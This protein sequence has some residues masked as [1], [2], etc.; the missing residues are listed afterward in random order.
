MKSATSVTLGLWVALGVSLA[1]AGPNTVDRVY[2]LDTGRERM[3]M[4]SAPGG[5][6]LFDAKLDVYRIYRYAPLGKGDITRVRVIDLDEDGGPEII[7]IGKPSFGLDAGGNPVWDYPEGCSELGVGDL[8]DTPEKEVVCVHGRTLTALSYNGSMMWEVDLRGAKMTGLGV[9][10]LDTDDGKEDVEVQVGKQIWRYKGDGSQ[11]GTEFEERRTV[12]QDDWAEQ[13]AEIKATLAGERSF[14]LDHDG[15]AEETL[16]A[17]GAKLSILSKGKAEPLG[18]Y[19]LPTGP[20]LSVAVGALGEEGKPVIVVGG[21]GIVAFLAG[22][23]AVL[24]EQRVDF[25]KADRSPKVE[26]VGVNAVG[27]EDR[28]AAAGRV[29]SI[30]DKAGECYAK[31]H[32]AYA[33]TRQGKTMFKFDVNAKG[34][35]S[36]S[37]ILYTTLSDGQVDAC[38]RGLGSKL[39]FPTPTEDGAH[40]TA[41]VLFTWSDR[42][43]D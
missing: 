7:G 15:T 40:C 42:C 12:P 17:E 41:D 13:A 3:A 32:R 23:G 2:A 14:D 43:K 36:G 38:I 37:E 11:L 35:V 10:M 33:L 5:L 8:L 1:W 31:R 29:Q 27:F 30:L 22:N 16:K 4:A 9:G 39:S 34:K 19:T 25:R 20:I 28:E 18:Q 26:F 24:K 21:E 6:V